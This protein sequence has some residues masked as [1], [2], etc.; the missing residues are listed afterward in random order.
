MSDA[1]HN[2]D[3]LSGAQAKYF[4]KTGSYAKSLAKLDVN[5]QGDK[6]VTKNFTYF[7]GDSGNGNY[8]I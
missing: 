2:I 1:L 6:V 5:A 7:L 8:C 4:V 3:M